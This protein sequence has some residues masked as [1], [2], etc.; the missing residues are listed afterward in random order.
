[1]IVEK[2]ATLPPWIEF[3][4]VRFELQL[5][6]NG[7]PDDVR[8]VYWLQSAVEGTK[9]YQTVNEYSCWNNPFCENKP[10]GF[11]FLTENIKTDKQLLDAIARCRI[12][13]KTNHLL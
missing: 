5:I 12:F 4:G 10:Q 6:V 1:M 9:H 2:F 11:L 13:L 8:L 7:S 3:E